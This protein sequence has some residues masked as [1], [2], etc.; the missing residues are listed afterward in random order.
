MTESLK[1]DLSH[2]VETASRVIQNPA[3]FYRDMPRTGGYA[4][5]LIFVASIAVIAGLLFAIL[6]L[7]GGARL[8]GMSTGLASIIV[9]PIA[10]IIGCFISSAI[11][12][13]IWKLMGSKQKYETAFRCQ[14]FASTILPITAILSLAPYLGS[15]ITVLW[16]TWLVI[17]A[18]TEVHGIP[19]QKAMLVFGI[20][21][22][23]MAYSNIANER[24][25]RDMQDQFE[26]ADPNIEQS[27]QN[28]ED[29]S[30][31]EAGKALGEFL[32]GLEQ[33]SKAE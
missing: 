29:M 9:M 17:N 3:G 25:A 27:L 32:K 14:A 33:G 5:P 16:G 6:S 31:E 1:F 23:I 13:V 21:G 4:Q 15:L 18:S 2:V 28:M 12:F 24:M 19:R 30:P 26:K 22:A 10:M 8:G 7:F 20:L 11:L